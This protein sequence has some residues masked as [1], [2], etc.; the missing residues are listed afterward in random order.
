MSSSF[1]PATSTCT[2][3]FITLTEYKSKIIIDNPSPAGLPNP[4]Y[5]R[6]RRPL[7]P[8]R[9]GG[10]EKV[11]TCLNRE[12]TERKHEIIPL[13]RHGRINMPDAFFIR[14]SYWLSTVWGVVWIVF[15]RE[16][17]YMLLGIQPTH[18]GAFFRESELVKEGIGISSTRKL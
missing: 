9:F 7:L 4:F 6:G 1:H 2:I 13:D 8:P 10:I 15:C 14:Q 11:P 12:L 3:D 18:G 5:R 17:M 16:T